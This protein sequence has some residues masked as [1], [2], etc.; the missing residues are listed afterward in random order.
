MVFRD[1]STEKQTTYRLGANEKAVFFMLNRSGNLVFELAGTG[2]EAHIFALFTGKGAD[3]AGLAITQRHLAP[4]TIS[5]A[6]IKSAL[7]DQASFVYDGLI[8]IEQGAVS[9]DASQECRT[10]LLSPDATSST[11]PALEI[12]VDDVSCRHAATTSSIDAEQLFF[13]QSRGLSKAQATELLVHG[14]FKD[15][16]DRMIT[17]NADKES[18]EKITKKL[19]F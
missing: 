11:K 10:L 17:L 2:A 6:L 4:K 1:I 8:R 18:M 16:L 3:K 5:H 15:I 19:S 14:F 7:S 13:A 12:L 9:S